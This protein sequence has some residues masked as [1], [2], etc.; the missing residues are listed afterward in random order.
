[1]YAIGKRE[2]R[3]GNFH[4]VL[5]REEVRKAQLLKLTKMVSSPNQ[6]PTLL[7]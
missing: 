4:L 6:L 7:P 3:R 5:E 1:M 2:E